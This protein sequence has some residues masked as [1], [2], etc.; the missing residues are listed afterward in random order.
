MDDP[1]PERPAGIAFGRFQVLPHRREVLSVGRPI[2]LGGRAFDVLMALIDARGALVTKDA[3][4]ARVW[5]GR[6]IEDNSLAAQI[7]ALRAAFGT[8]RALIRTVSGRGYQ[9][10]GD[11][12]AVPGSSDESFDAVAAQPVPVLP[13]TNAPEPVSEVIGRDAEIEEV[14]R[15]ARAHRLVTLTGAG[16]IGK[17]TLALAL[18]RELRP[19]FADGVWL[20]EFSALADPALVPAT[21]AAAVGLELGGGDVSAQRVAQ[22]LAGRRLLLVLDTCEHVIAAAAA[23]AEAILGTSSAPHV[24]ATSREALRAGGERVYPVQPLAV[25]A[26]YVASDDDPLRYSA[27][28]LFVERGRAAEPYFAPDRRLMTVIAAICRRLDGIPLAIELAAARAAALGIEALAARL[29]DRFR[30]LTRGRRTALPR[31]RAL[32]ATL[33]WS[34]ELLTEPERMIL[35]R[36]AVF[37]G[38][39]SLEACAAVAASPEL[40]VPDAI[41]GLL[42]LVAKS[43]VVTGAEGAVEGYRL[44]DTTRAYAFDK[45]A[46]RGEQEAVAR[47][48]AEYYRGFFERAEAEWGRRPAV[49]WLADYGWHLDDLRAALDWAFSPSGDASLGI[50]LTVAAVPL[51]TQLSLMQECRQRIERAL[52]SLASLATRDTRREMQ[53]LSAL[54]TARLVTRGTTP[55]AETAWQRALEIAE[56]LGDTNYRLR[57]LH[58]LYAYHLTNGEYREALVL[59]E[60]FHSLAM[61]GADT[62]AAAVMGE[63]WIGVVLHMLGDQ[64]RA[65]LLLEHALNSTVAID[66]R[67]H[68]INFQLDQRVATHCF[69][70]RT[71]WL[72]GVP[73]QAMHTMRAGIKLAHAIRHPLSLLY[74]LIQA[75][76]PVALFA[77]DI[78]AADRAVTMLLD[79]SDRHAMARWTLWGRCYQGVLL[80]QQGDVATASQLLRTALGQLAEAGFYNC[81]TFLTAE[82]ASALGRA[83]EAAQG[84][85]AIDA[86]LAR[87]E[88]SEQGWCT[89][90]LLRIKGEL[91][92]LQAEEGA[93]AAAEYH[94]RQAL[95]CAHRQG[96]L[97]WEL[98]AGTSL[99]RLL[100]EQG[101]SAEAPALLQPIYDHFTEGFD[102]A[103]L[104]AAKALLDALADPHH[105]RGTVRMLR[106]N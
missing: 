34:Y 13:P 30:L 104:K 88:R 5:P 89:A 53:L 1:A 9:F 73:D 96:A 41:E 55:E 7:A 80:A 98:R 72:Q 60:R 8:E 71:L 3:L 46:G 29:D 33:D 77:G 100:R 69:L 87:T 65:R 92:L 35:R 94:F 52:A 61:N 91:L 78:A 16:G 83:G 49:E 17:T 21:V 20:A 22:A 99:A 24:I 75:A 56:S 84:F 32:R 85:A 81:Y 40:S 102:T 23:V 18:A 66:D 70:A 4:M 97:S 62:A 103:D 42:G 58:G 25:P 90:E 93:A 105:A 76:C 6:I 27:V 45:L 79:L 15:V 38:A 12:R 64:A 68:V 57:G 14:L 54:G 2:T 36:L 63:M 31:H 37:A 106:V 101:R 50:I 95:E 67:R 11:I 51:W 82:L 43:L 74:A 86:A 19:H 44:L 39:F 59:A 26:E 28:R 47:L 48:H 10:T